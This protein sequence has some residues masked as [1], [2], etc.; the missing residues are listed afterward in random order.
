MATQY[1]DK[2]DTYTR[3]IED[4]DVRRGMERLIKHVSQALREIDQRLEKL[5]SPTPRATER[6]DLPFTWGEPDE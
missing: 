3:L 5:G 4:S 6:P 2:P 1:I